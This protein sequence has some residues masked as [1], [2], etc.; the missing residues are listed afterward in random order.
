M[1]AATGDGSTARDVL[2]VL[3]T[4]NVAPDVRVVAAANDGTH[5]EKL[6]SVGA[7]EV[8]N[9]LAIGGRLLG[10]SVLEGEGVEVPDV[11]DA[12]NGG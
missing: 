6:E 4:R 10:R 3:A 9:P 12:E 7:D 2:A 11:A 5:V 1:S 8:I